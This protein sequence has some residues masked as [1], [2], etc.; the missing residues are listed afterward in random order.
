MR[1]P[2]KETLSSF[3]DF[4]QLIYM[5]LVSLRLE[6]LS[7]IRALLQLYTHTHTHTTMLVEL[8]SGAPY[9][10]QRSLSDSSKE[11]FLVMHW[12]PEHC[13][14]SQAITLSV[15]KLCQIE[16]PELVVCDRV[17]KLCT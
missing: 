10:N 16:K 15:L 5:G 8:R 6:D 9:T 13:M 14:Y 11:L 17:G 2:C 4:V 12:F 1:F 7:S 3:G